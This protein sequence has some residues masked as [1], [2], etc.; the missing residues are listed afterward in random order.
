M[1]Q[2]TVCS[3]GTEQSGMLVRVNDNETCALSLGTL[4]ALPPRCHQVINSGQPVSQDGGR[5]RPPVG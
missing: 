5:R 3:R 4:F 1:V 2:V